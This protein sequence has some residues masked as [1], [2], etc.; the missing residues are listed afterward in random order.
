MAETRIHEPPVLTPLFLGMNIL[1]NAWRQWFGNISRHSHVTCKIESDQSNSTTT[2]ADATGLVFSVK[3]GRYYK[4]QFSVVFRTAAATTGIALTVTT[5][6]FTI[7][8]GVSRIPIGADGTDSTRIGHHTTSADQNV[9]TAVQAANT[10]YLALFDVVIVPSANG[11]VQLQFRSEV[12]AS[13]VTIKQG[14]CGIM[15]EN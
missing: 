9:G 4:I 2:L 14:S 1:S 3:S 12:N 15:Y 6:T 11:K 8:S 10:D 5:P 7:F 13:A